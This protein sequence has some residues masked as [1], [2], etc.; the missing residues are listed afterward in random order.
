MIKNIL[1]KIVSNKIIVFVKKIK[2]NCE[3]FLKSNDVIVTESELEKLEQ[4]KLSF[5]NVMTTKQTLD[6]IIFDG[7]SICRYGDAEFDISN[8]ENQNDNYQSPSN[9]L[10]KRLHDILLH[11]SDHKLLVCIPPFN[12]K[13]N[14]IKRYYGSLSFWEWYWLHKFEKLRKLFKSPIYG[15][16][17]VTRETVFHENDVNYIKKIWEDR[18]VVFVY[19]QKGRF[20]LESVLFDNVKAKHEL[21]VPPVNAFE[22][23]SSILQECKSFDRDVL[24]MIAAGPTAAVLAFDLW[25]LGY[26]AIDIGHL[27]NS[28]DEYKGEILSP[29]DIPLV[30]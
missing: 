9:E 20:N 25:E 23:Y 16:S 5:P 17:F 29:E 11:G 4:Y 12:S 28:Y 1:K 19:S 22:K 14:N 7:A 3:N 2:R 15:N 10:T 24:F 18:T 6:Q 26:Q 8:Q 21:Y 13:T 27:P 30:S